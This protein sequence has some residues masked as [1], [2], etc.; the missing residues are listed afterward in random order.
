LLPK[1]TLRIKARRGWIEERGSAMVSYRDADGTVVPEIDVPIRDGALDHP[2]C[3]PY[4]SVYVTSP[5]RYEMTVTDDKTGSV[6]LLLVTA[7]MSQPRY[8]LD[9]DGL[10]RTSPDGAIVPG[11][12]TP[13]ASTVKECMESS[14]CGRE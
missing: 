11:S 12:K 10:Y 13:L 5:V 14:W 7:D 2:A 1:G 4:T 9:D 8:R 3:V 6:L